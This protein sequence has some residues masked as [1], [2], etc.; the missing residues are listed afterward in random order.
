MPRC[1]HCR[2]KFDKA[3][4]NQQYCFK[5]ACTRAWINKCNTARVTQLKKEFVKQHGESIPML[6]KKLKHVFHLYIRTRDKNKGCISCGKPLPDKYDAGHF[7]NS[8]N[9]SNIRYHE[10]NVHA[11]CVRCNRDLHGNLLEYQVRLKLKIG[12]ERYEMLEAERNVMKKWTRTELHN[13]IQ[14]YKEKNKNFQLSVQP[15][16]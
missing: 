2:E 8:N 3:H 16:V 15:I 6:H 10:D 1:K 14:H 9:H 7:W 4:F 11:Q 13:L 5:T 12:I